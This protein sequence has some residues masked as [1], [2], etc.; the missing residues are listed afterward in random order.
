MTKNRTRTPVYLEPGMH[1][2]LEVKGLNGLVLIRS[3]DLAS[4]KWPHFIRP[5]KYS[6]P[7]ITFLQVASRANLYPVEMRGFSHTVTMH[8]GAARRGHIYSSVAPWQIRF[9]TNIDFARITPT[10]PPPLPPGDHSDPKRYQSN[11]YH[12]NCWRW[13]IL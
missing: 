12:L 11:K 2:G 8:D 5:S 10:P 6:A 13:V 9:R 3:L 7:D 1:P 4:W